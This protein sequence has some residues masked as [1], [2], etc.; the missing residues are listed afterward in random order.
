[1]L[2]NS[3]ETHRHDNYRRINLFRGMARIVLSLNRIPLPRIG[4]LTIDNRGLISL[5]NRPLTLL[6]QTLE[7]ENIP[8]KISRD[9][10]YPAIELYLLDLLGC[11]DSRIRYQPN[12]VHDIEDGKQ[13]LAALATMR[14]VL[15]HFVSRGC[16]YGPF[17]FT[18]TDLHQ[19]NIFVDDDWNITSLIDLEWA[20]SLPIE[21]QGPPHWLTSRAVDA[22]ADEPSLNDYS[23]AVGE[24]IDAFKEEETKTGT[25]SPYQATIMRQCWH[26]SSF[27]YFQ[28]VNSPKGLYLLF[29]N[30]IQGLFH[31]MHARQKIFDEVVAPYW[32]RDAEAVI[33]EKLQDEA[34]Y[35][36]ELRKLFK[37]KSAE[38]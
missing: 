6:L 33:Q 20:C 1:M 5:K 19:S 18:L 11:H 34:K 17:H 23:Q 35:K 26:T 32:G 9:T 30:H 27:W 37:E 25:D 31:A 13:Q 10:L 8:T 22:M 12:S 36:D 38:E 3:W 14:T 2:S 4:S 28:A 21:M 15:H 29:N 7:N 16:R 24:F